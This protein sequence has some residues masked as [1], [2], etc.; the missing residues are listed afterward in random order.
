MFF[1]ISN[2]VRLLNITSVVKL[3]EAKINSSKVN[4]KLSNKLFSLLKF[5]WEY[6]RKI[7]IRGIPKKWTIDKIATK[8][9]EESSNSIGIPPKSYSFISVSI[10]NYCNNNNNSFRLELYTNN[11]WFWFWLC[12]C[13]HFQEMQVLW[14]KKI[15]WWKLVF[16]SLKALYSDFK[17]FCFAMNFLVKSK[18]IVISKRINDDNSDVR[19]VKTA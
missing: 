10:I 1:K 11:F 13:T 18:P 15:F 7:V 6:I 4:H 2:F 17:P 5:G 12:Y 9:V 16:V 8:R 3:F 19:A 14:P